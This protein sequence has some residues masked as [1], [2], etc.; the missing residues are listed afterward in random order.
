MN[1]KT[2]WKDTKHNDRCT[3]MNVDEKE[4]IKPSY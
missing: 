1:A 2:S 3:N 4:E